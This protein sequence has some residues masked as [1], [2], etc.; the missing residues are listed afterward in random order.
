MHHE[1]L[2][3]DQ[4]EVTAILIRTNNPTAG[5]TLP[6]AINKGPVAQAVMPIRE[7]R[8]L[9]D[10]LIGNLQMILLVLSVLIVVVAG[11][12]IMVSI[13]NSM[14]DR[15]R[16]I[17]IMR[18]LGAGRGTVRTLILLES[19]LLSVLGGLAGF[20]L[21]HG[22]I[23]LLSPYIASHTGVPIGAFQFVPAEL[24]LIP[25]LV[26][27]ATLAG[28]LPALSAYRTDVSRALSQSP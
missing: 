28:Y 11:I 27:L 7:I 4:R 5:F 6:P 15:R 1:P 22:L 10:G 19:I 26:L 13:Y 9:F 20:L 14:S 21:G 17:A 2:P 12:G 24:V 23:G 16:E 18:A 8:K 3:E 25:G